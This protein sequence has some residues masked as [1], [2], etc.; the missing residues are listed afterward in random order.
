MKCAAYT[1]AHLHLSGIVCTQNS[2]S[3]ISIF[4]GD[5]D[6]LNNTYALVANA[7]ASGTLPEKIGGNRFLIIGDTLK[8]DNGLVYGVQLACGFGS[9][10]LAIRNCYYNKEATSDYTDWRYI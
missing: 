3:P 10:K 7:E 1:V 8:H 5:I 6:F 9:N 2:K 4:K